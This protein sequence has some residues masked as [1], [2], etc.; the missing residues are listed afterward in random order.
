MV[1]LT[2][3]SAILQGFEYCKRHDLDTAECLDN[4]DELKLGDPITHHQVIALSKTI[5]QHATLS[6]A[7]D[8]RDFSLSQL[9]R[10][11]EVYIEPPKPKPEPVSNHTALAAVAD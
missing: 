3:T 2:V 9:L 1:R 8:S 6:N 5:K 10:G 4:H 7:T 11:S